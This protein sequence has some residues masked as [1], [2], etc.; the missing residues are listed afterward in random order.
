MEKDKEPDEILEE[1]GRL[2]ALYSDLSEALFEV[3]EYIKDNPLPRYIRVM[4]RPE[5]GGVM[6]LS[7]DY[8]AIFIAAERLKE[9]GD[10][11]KNKNDMG[12]PWL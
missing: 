2:G 5:V 10:F 1:S 7:T 6:G 9:I 11:I 3:A 12:S 8:A 4:L